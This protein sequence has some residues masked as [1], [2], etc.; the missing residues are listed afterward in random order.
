[1][2]LNNTLDFKE[3]LWHI[4]PM[5]EINYR[6]PGLIPIWFLLATLIAAGCGKQNSPTNVAL[7]PSES[8]EESI[9]PPALA[10][11]KID[12]ER[13]AQNSIKGKWEITYF[14]TRRTDPEVKFLNQPLQEDR[15]V[16]LKADDDNLEFTL[17]N[18]KNAPTCSITLKYQFFY[19]CV[20]MRK[21]TLNSE[22][23]QIEESSPGCSQVEFGK[24]A[25]A[26]GKNLDKAI[27]IIG[28][29]SEN[30]IGPQF[31]FNFYK[32]HLNLR[33][34]WIT[35]TQK[36]APKKLLTEIRLIELKK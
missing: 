23:L 34:S 13:N 22:S 30:E 36:N 27:T 7:K 28:S 6:L 31:H 2:Q 4:Y 5:R 3:N 11:E 15:L 12:N 21:I 24:T 17:S 18:H 35:G 25:Q 19:C 26:L 9:S 8:S 29:P 33:G 1:M 20:P 16:T 10:N 14:K 32:S